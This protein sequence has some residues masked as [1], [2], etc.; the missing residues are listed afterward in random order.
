MFSKKPYG[1]HGYP[2][3]YRI[4][5]FLTAQRLKGK[6]GY[7]GL[8]AVRPDYPENTPINP[9]SGIYPET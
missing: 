3:E 1:P 5:L 2:Q 4:A 6:P 7:P 9:V 8:S